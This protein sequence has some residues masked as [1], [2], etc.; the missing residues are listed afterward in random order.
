M[1]LIEFEF[2]PIDQLEDFS[3]AHWWGLTDAYFCMNVGNQTLFELKEEFATP[4]SRWVDYHLARLHQE[5]IAMLPTVLE[6]IPDALVSR[7][8]TLE[9]Q[10]Q[11]LAT[12]EQVYEDIP[13]EDE[14]ADDDYSDAILWLEEDRCLDNTYLRSMPKVWILQIGETIH[15]RWQSR[16]DES[17]W[18]ATAGE[19]QIS[20]ESFI[21]E[22]TS[23]HDR[24]ITGMA[25]R[26]EQLAQAV[27]VDRANF[28]PE[29]EVWASKLQEALNTSAD[30]DWD[31]VQ[32]AI[33]RFTSA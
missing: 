2:M 18:T 33:D 15:I 4:E 7:V 29:Q 25:P 6:P 24:L 3:R 31:C 19:Y 14:E 13:D 30:T 8:S 12:I 26:I 21:E 20:R 23:F 5:L 32:S 11:L 9:A 28:D 17:I 22:I 1:S 27:E 10:T 16:D